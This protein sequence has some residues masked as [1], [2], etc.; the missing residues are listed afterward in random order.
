MAHFRLWVE[1]IQVLRVGAEKTNKQKTHERFSDGPCGTIV[2]GTNPHPSQGQTGQN[3]DFTVEVN[4]KRPVFPRDGSQ[5]V[6]GRGP[7]CPRDGVPFVPD[8]VP[9]KMFMFIGFFLAQESWVHPRFLST[10]SWC[11]SLIFWVWGEDR[12]D[13]WVVSAQSSN[14]LCKVFLGRCPDSSEELLGCAKFR[15]RPGLFSLKPGLAVPKLG[16]FR[17]CDSDPV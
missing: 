17:D 8:T 16:L 14:L 1:F 2:P 12:P 4:R 9:P 3:G 13:F 15:L 5:F 11:Q 6:L 7:V 10:L